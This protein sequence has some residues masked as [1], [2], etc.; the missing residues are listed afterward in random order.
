[1]DK[2]QKLSAIA[3]LQSIGGVTLLETAAS[4]SVAIFFGQ[5]KDRNSIN[6]GTIFFVDFG[7]GILGITAAHVYKAYLDKKQNANFICQIGGLRFNPEDHLIDVDYNLDIA[8]FNIDRNIIIALNKQ[9]HSPLNWPPKIMPKQGDDVF[10]AG[11]PAIYRA[12]SG[13][14]DVEFG[15]AMHMLIVDSVNDRYIRCSYSET[16]HITRGINTS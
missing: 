13:K 15:S 4:Y 3:A 6:N 16:I 10:L 12:P 1:M 14:N 11:F 5:A 2:H 8:T 9:V 7:Q